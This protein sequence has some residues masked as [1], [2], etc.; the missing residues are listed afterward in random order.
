MTTFDSKTP[1]ADDE[2]NPKKNFPTYFKISVLVAALSFLVY[3]IYW[4]IYATSWFYTVT[5]MFFGGTNFA[6]ANNL[7][8][9]AFQEYAAIVG[10]YLILIGSIFAMYCVILFIKS[11]ARYVKKLGKAVIFTSLF[12]ILL[13]PSSIRHFVGVA[14]T[15]SQAYNIYVGFSNL[16]QALLIGVPLLMIGRKLIKPQN[17]VSILKWASITAPLCVFGFWSYASLLWVYALSPLGPKHASLMST[18]GAANSLLTLL[19]AGIITTIVCLNYNQKKILN[20]KLAGAAVIL[21]GMYAV[22]YALVSIWVPIYF[23]FW[24]LTEIWLIVLPILGI[25]I[26]K[27]KSNADNRIIIR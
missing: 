25:T 19:I 1:D 15:S 24:Y 12:Y 6:L 21:V 20:K 4:A 3:H 11:D 18:I 17:H 14:T 2:T 16:L 10:Y 7:F 26:I 8:L 22:V 5:D 13:I 23:S 9:L 27:L